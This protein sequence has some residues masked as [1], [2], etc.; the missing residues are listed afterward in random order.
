[1]IFRRI[2]AH[3]E[4]E[5]WFAVFVDF[6][7]V[8]V[9]V[10]IG[11][12]VANWN[13]SR[14]TYQ[15]ETRLLH[16][17]KREVE[18]SIVLSNHHITSYQQVTNAGKRSLEFIAQGKPCEDNCWAIIVDFM[19]ASQW[20]SVSVKRSSYENMRSLGFPKNT[21]IIDA[22]ESYLDQNTD[23]NDVF[24][25][26]PVYRSLVRQI[27]PFDAA[28]FYWANCYRLL[29]GIEEYVLDC[30]KGMPDDE[31]KKTVEEI[32]QNK[33][34]KPHLTEWAASIVSMPLTLGDQNTAAQRAIDLI[35][36]ELDLR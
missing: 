26:L 35:N 30:P 17:L 16:E 21:L 36:D 18:K 15:T 34:I 7:I 20:Q 24:K 14:A 28:Q 2:K 29:D 12:Q 9:G 3:I 4:K 13:D 11:I 1:M 19:H 8:V 32:I 25:V 22:I 23:N 33:N 6:L 31:A 27:V 5:N 10:F